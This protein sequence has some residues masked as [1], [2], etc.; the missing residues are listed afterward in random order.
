MVLE[1]Q[2]NINESVVKNLISDL[3][4]EGISYYLINDDG[5]KKVF[6]NDA[7]NR[8]ATQP[9]IAKGVVAVGILFSIGNKIPLFVRNDNNYF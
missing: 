3:D 8:L 1:L 7:T 9:L 4:S 6:V 2:K 5:I